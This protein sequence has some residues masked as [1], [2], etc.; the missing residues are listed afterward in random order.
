MIYSEEI[1]KRNEINQMNPIISI[2][3]PVFNEEENIRELYRRLENTLARVEKNYEIVFIDDCSQDRSFELLKEVYQKNKNI[4]I[5]RLAKNFG[6]PAAILAGLQHARGSI[7]II[8]DAD[9]QFNPEDILKLIRKIEEGYDAVV[10]YRKFRCDALFTR[11]VPSFFMNKIISMKTGIKLKDW[12]CPFAAI[13]KEIADQIVSYG[14]NAR[15]IKPLGA[16]FANNF[17]EIEIE[18][19]KRKRGKSK[20]SSFGLLINAIDFF[21]N[22]SSKLSKCDKTIFTIGE[23]IY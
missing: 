16:S 2:I 12:G 10:A 14:K 4:N 5:I 19:H 9:L 11:R 3:I 22:Y 8:M 17:T 6:Q 21:V 1:A 15:F 23:I 20:Y 7:I 13:K 18:H